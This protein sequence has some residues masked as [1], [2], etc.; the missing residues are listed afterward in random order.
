VYQATLWNLLHLFPTP[1]NNVPSFEPVFIIS[2]RGNDFYAYDSFFFNHTPKF[3]E[4]FITSS[5]LVAGIRVCDASITEITT[6]RCR[7]L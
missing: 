6:L 5:R 1:T 2:T 7:S 3:G 4:V